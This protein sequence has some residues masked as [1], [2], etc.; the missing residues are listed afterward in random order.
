GNFGVVVSMSFKLYPI[1]TVLSGMIMHPLERAKEVIRFY[2]DF[3]ANAPDEL[4]VYVAALTTPDGFEAL[5]I[6]PCYCGDNLAD[7]ERLLQPL[8]NFG[9]PVADMV[10]PMRYLALQQMLD[11]ACPYGI[12]SYWKSSFLR[13]L[14]DDAIDT[15]VSHVR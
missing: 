13:D 11:P 12:R 7:G 10:G 8:R 9:P 2:R 15:F 3:V 14:S 4:T 1:T 5:A 6:V